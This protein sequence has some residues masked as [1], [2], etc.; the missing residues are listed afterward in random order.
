MRAPDVLSGGHRDRAGARCEN[1]V[2]IKIKMDT[3]RQRASFVS[4]P[5]A[6]TLDVDRA[7]QHADRDQL[8]TS[9]P[10]HRQTPLQAS[11]LATFILK[12]HKSVWHFSKQTTTMGNKM[13]YIFTIR[14]YKYIMTYKIFKKKQNPLMP[15]RLFW[16]H[17]KQRVI[18]STFSH[19]FKKRTVSEINICIHTHKTTPAPSQSPTTQE[20]DCLEGVEFS[21]RNCILKKKYKYYMYS[22]YH[23]RFTKTRTRF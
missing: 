23:S 21:P 7:R 13:T 17:T 22:H 4:D 16:K 10:V 5:A 9:V 1:S 19:R 20:H 14:L 6:V 15:Q 8:E 12:Q 18:A 11:I 2:K 3:G